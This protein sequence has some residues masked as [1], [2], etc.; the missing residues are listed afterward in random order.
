M[1]C[2]RKKKAMRKKIKRAERSFCRHV[3]LSTA[4]TLLMIVALI[5]IIVSI[6][7]AC[8]YHKTK[9][10]ILDRNALLSMGVDF[11]CILVLGCGVYSDGTPTPMLADRVETAASLYATEICDR[12]LMSGDYRDENY[13]EVGVMKRV[14]E[15]HGVPSNAIFTDPLGLSTYDS[16]MRFAAERPGARVIIVT[17]SYHLCRALYLAEKAGLDAYGV[18]ADL[19]SYVGQIKYDLREIAARCKDV[20]YAETKPAVAGIN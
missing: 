16:I 15:G 5:G 11:E 4:F 6:I 7:S 9:S 20:Y 14:A 17:Q 19:R 13:N 3:L 1:A 12:L 18:S 10:R 2:L 8:V